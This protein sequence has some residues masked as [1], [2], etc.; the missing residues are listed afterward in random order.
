MEFKQ[1][2]KGERLTLKIT[3][4]TINHG[5]EVFELVEKNKEYLRKW[6][7]WVDKTESVEDTTKYLFSQ[8]EEIKEKQTVQYGIYLDEKLIGKLS[9]MNISTSDKSGEIGYWLSEEFSGKGYMTEAVK[10]LET[11]GFENIGLNRIQIKCDIENNASIKVAEK[12]NYQFEGIIRQETFSPYF[13][14]L[15]DT[16]LFSKLKKEYEKEQDEKN[17]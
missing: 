13:N 7:P 16:K 14:E 6:L 10:L 11:E 17:R 4:A 15:R 2:L 1:E 3:L 5:K 12:C 8:E 9:I